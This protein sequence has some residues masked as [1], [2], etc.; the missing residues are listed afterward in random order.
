MQ[1]SSWSHV[2]ASCGTSAILLATMGYCTDSLFNTV[3]MFIV[4][5]CLVILNSLC[6]Q[7]CTVMTVEVW[8]SWLC[9]LVECAGLLFALYF[10]TLKIHNE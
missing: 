1:N 3:F 6:G 2:C 9:E 7:A 10:Y 4:L 5:N 8:L